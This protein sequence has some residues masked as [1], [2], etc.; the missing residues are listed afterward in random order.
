MI[1]GIVASVP[2]AASGSGT[3]EYLSDSYWSATVGDHFW[4]GLYW[5]RDSSD[6]DFFNFRF[7]AV[8]G[9][10]VG[11]RPTTVNIIMNSLVDGGNGGVFGGDSIF[12]YDA[13]FNT[14][15]TSSLDFSGYADEINFNV[16][17]DFTGTDDI[18]FMEINSFLYNQGPRITFIEFTVP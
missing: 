1:N 9:W 4:N 10:E 2:Y 17:I 18:A 8:N 12:F 16:S 13:S 7:A 14:I 11:F 6:A 15:G 3:F 5:Q